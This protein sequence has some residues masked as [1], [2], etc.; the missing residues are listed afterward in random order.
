MEENNSSTTTPPDAIHEATTPPGQGVV[1][2]EAVRKSRAALELA[3][4]AH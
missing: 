3:A 1:D 2:E 4:G